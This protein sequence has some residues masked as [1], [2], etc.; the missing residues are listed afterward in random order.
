MKDCQARRNVK[1]AEE[2]NGRLVSGLVSTSSEWSGKYL[3]QY[4][5]VN[6]SH[7]GWTGTEYLSPFWAAGEIDLKHSATLY[8]QQSNGGINYIVD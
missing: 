1:D 6:K 7:M 3:P 5:N 8:K 2:N 4:P